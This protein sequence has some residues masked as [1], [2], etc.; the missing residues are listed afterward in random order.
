[1]KTKNKKT[2]SRER[3]HARIRAKVAGTSLCPRISIFK[4]NKRIIA[5]LI[6]DTKGVTIVAV[7]D[8]DANGK[9]KTERAEK[10]GEM[11][12]KTAKEKGVTKAVFD[13]GGFLY[14]GRVRAFADGA[15]KGGIHF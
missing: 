12:A 10:A 13:R 11:F 4:S 7:S 3:R 5:Q 9:T 8:L 14:T 6:D 15:R 1:M 2:E